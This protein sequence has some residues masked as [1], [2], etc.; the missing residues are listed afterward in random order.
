MQKIVVLASLLG[1][2]TAAWSQQSVLPSKSTLSAAQCVQAQSDCA[3]P[4]PAVA[5]APAVKRNV[6][7]TPRVAAPAVVASPGMPNAAPGECFARAH[8]EAEYRTDTE[9]VL[10]RAAT[11]N[12][13]VIPARFVEAEEVVTIREASTKLELVPATYKTV[14]EGIV[15]APASKRLET[16]PGGMESV[17]ERVLVQPARSVW[18]RGVNIAG[19]PTKQDADG[20]VLCLVEEPAVYKTVTRQV[21]KPDTVRE[22]DV[23][24]VRQTVNKTVVDTPANAREIAIPAVTKVVKVR[25]LVEPAREV[26]EDV[27]AEYEKVSR[28]TLVQPAGWQWKQVLCETNATPAKL[29]EIQAALRAKGLE[30]DGSLKS[31]LQSL[32]TFRTAQGMRAD[33][34]ITV[35]SLKL[36]GVSE[37]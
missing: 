9:Q 8:Y 18:K 10:K 17:T 6:V 16:I 22:I 27:P 12:V 5:A 23:P 29:T 3:M 21:R 14:T 25:K 30:S 4:K 32:N 1:A 13:K 11:R 2:A 28:K 37:K 26:S 15:V 19:L 35:D 7:R 34:F 20:E 31:T 33:Q 24:E 36:L